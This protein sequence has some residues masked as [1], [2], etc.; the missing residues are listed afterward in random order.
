VGNVGSAPGEWVING[1]ALVT[2]SAAGSINIE[3]I[4]ATAENLCQTLS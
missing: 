4:H 1:L 3:L 2:V